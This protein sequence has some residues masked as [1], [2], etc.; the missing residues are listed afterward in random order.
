[1]KRFSLIHVFFHVNNNVLLIKKFVI[2]ATLFL[3]G[4]LNGQT[5]VE[6]T[7]KNR[8]A[9]F[10]MFTGINCP[11]CPQGA[12]IAKQIYEQYP[13]RVVLIAVHQGSFAQPSGSQP[14]F[15]T[16]FGNSLAQLAGVQAYPCATINRHLFPQYAYPSGSSNL[17]IMRNN[18]ASAADIIMNLPA[19][20]N[21]GAT[22][23][24]DAVT[25]QISVYT[26]VYYTANSSQSTNKINVVLLQDKTYGPQNGG[27][28]GDNYEHNN[29]LVHMIT[30]QWGA[31]INQTSE[32]SLY[33]NTFTY[34]I[35]DSYNGIP[36]LL[37]NLRVAVYVTESNNKETINGIQIT[38][39]FINVPTEPEFQIVSNNTP[40]DVWDGIISPQFNVLS[41]CQNLDT[42]EIQYKVNNENLHHYTWIGDLP[43]GQQTTI[44][45]PEISFTPLLNNTLSVEILTPDNSPSNNSYTAS[46]IK[47]VAT[48]ATSLTVSVKPDAYGSEITWRIKNDSGTILANGGPYQNNNTNIQ[49]H[50]LNLS[51]GNYVLEVFD[52]YGDGVPGGYIALK[53]GNTTIFTIQGNSYG[54]SAAKKFRIVN[55]V[56]ITFTPSQGTTDAPG[57]GPFT[58]LS[59]KTLFTGSNA[60][61]TNENLPVAVRLKTNNASGQN[62]PFSGQ[63]TEGRNISIVPTNEIAPGTLVYFSFSGKDEDGIVINESATFTIST[64][65]IVDESFNNIAINPNPARNQFEIQG[66]DSG[67]LWVYSCDG[68]ILHQQKISDG[69]STVN[70]DN[71]ETGVVYIK[72]E[73]NGKIL[74]K[75]L[76]I[77]R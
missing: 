35:P 70:L 30:G 46:F 31:E 33:T 20:A 59:S 54:T 52:S 42:L 55:P 17:A 76:V 28:A 60:L 73:S 40:A 1:M 21:V 2:A 41:L 23:V 45:L 10:E 72:I 56:T 71:P 69:L 61:I 27:G 4:L 48:T 43:Y 32:G 39:A 24:I 64:V 67:T 13:N 22:A 8:N 51:L 77:V 34:T 25:R 7:P 11:Y 12:A 65:G 36:A 58:I 68:R 18:Y 44:T 66:I 57:T 16:P 62:I 3:P 26:E 74:V 9:V 50:D 5:I 19:Y 37:Q 75:P 53:N 63:I 14:D 6:T 47:A 29:R 15:R 38:P 49:N